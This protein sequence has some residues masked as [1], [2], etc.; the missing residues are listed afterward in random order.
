[1]ARTLIGIDGSKGAIKPLD[2][3]VAR[4]RRGSSA[5]LRSANNQSAWSSN[6]QSHGE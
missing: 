5:A 3:V 2:Y 4:K 1:M 6:D